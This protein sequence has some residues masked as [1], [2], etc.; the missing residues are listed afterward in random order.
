MELEQAIIAGSFGVIVAIVTW[1]LAG[2]RELNVRKIEQKKVRVEKLEQL[3]AQTISLLEMAIR[4]T[5]GTP[6]SGD[7][8]RKL[9]E[10]NGYLKLLAS[11]RVNNQVEEISV[12]LFRWSTLHVKGAPKEMGGNMLAISSQDSKYQKEAEELFP[13]VNE[14]IVML[15]Q[16]MKE[17]LSA[18]ENA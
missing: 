13:K 7:L 4:I 5:R 6:E 14:S 16:L 15:I 8:E 12:L 9:S 18:V 10:N 11:D 1:L 2:L 3:Y 17:H